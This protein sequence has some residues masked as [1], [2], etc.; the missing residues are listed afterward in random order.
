MIIGIDFETTGLD[1]DTLDIVEIAIVLYT[2]GLSVYDTYTQ[3]FRLSVDKIDACNDVV[4]Q[5]HTENGLWDEV[6][7]SSVHPEDIKDDLAAL[8]DEWSKHGNLK[9]APL[10]G[11][12]VHFDRAILKRF[13]PEIHDRVS[14]RNIDVS[15]FNEL[16]KR[17]DPIAVP[18][19]VMTHRALDDVKESAR[20]LKEY[21]KT[22][23]NT[24]ISVRLQDLKSRITTTVRGLFGAR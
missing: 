10:M 19:A 17:W 1:T 2:D 12:S 18:R 5:M 16:A 21:R 24:A 7:E 11:N 15:S 22:W 6:L 23:L 20:T 8:F 3:V 13:F 14:H 9:K 4:K